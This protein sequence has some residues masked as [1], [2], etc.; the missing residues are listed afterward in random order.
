MPP[1]HS[2]LLTLEKDCKVKTLCIYSLTAI[3]DKISGQRPSI[4]DAVDSLLQLSGGRS[5][6]VVAVLPRM[7]TIHCCCVGQTVR[8]PDKLPEGKTLHTLQLKLG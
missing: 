6:A 3:L 1:L 7:D 8:R 4:T 5:V 2:L